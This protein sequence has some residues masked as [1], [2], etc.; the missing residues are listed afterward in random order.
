[1]ISS[2]PNLSHDPLQYRVCSTRTPRSTGRTGLGVSENNIGN[3]GK[4]TQKKK[5]LK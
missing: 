4:H 3:G 5:A 2:V 1:M